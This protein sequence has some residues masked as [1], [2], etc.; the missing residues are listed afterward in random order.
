MRTT[1]AT[2]WTQSMNEMSMIVVLLPSST[3]PEI[4]FILSSA[5]SSRFLAESESS[6]KTKSI[7]MGDDDHDART[8]HCGNLAQDKITEDILYELFLQVSSQQF[9]HVAFISHVFSL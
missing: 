3:A 8:I 9:G 2:Q 1:S 7:N 6:N 5:T 4:L